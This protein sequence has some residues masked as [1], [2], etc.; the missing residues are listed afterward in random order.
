MADGAFVALNAD[1]LLWQEKMR[2]CAAPSISFAVSKGVRVRVTYALLAQQ[3]GVDWK[4]RSYDVAD[5]EA[6]ELPR[7]DPAPEAAGPAFAD[8]EADRARE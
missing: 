8:P 1:R 7:P 5:W 4:R 2:P 6:G 3:Y